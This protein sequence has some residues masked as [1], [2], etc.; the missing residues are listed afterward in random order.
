M[1]PERWQQIRDVLEKALELGPD[2]RSGYLDRA[3][4]SDSSLRHEVEILL[5]SSADVRSSFLQSLT[6]QVTLTPGTKL[7]DYE[8]KS[9]LSSGG[10]GEVYRARDSRLARDVAIK[11]L[12]SFLLADSGRLRRFEQEARAA[13][14][15]SH[16]NILAV[17]QFG[18]YEGVP[19]LVTELLEG[20]TLREQIKRGPVAVRKAIDYGIQMARGL[21]AA[22]EKSIVHRDLKPENLFV[23][24][25][26]R[27]KI[28]D[29]GLAKLT[30]PPSSS[31]HSALT[32]VEGTEA[33]VVMGTVGYMSPEQ[34]RA[35]VADYRSDIFAL[36]A[37][38][39]EM[40]AGKR[41]FQ[42]PTSPETMTAILNEDPPGISQFVPSLPPSLQRVVRRCLEKK[43][44]QRFQSASDL[45]FA[46]DA[47]S[48]VSGSGEAYPRQDTVW[49][50]LFSVVR[51]H[52]LGLAAGIVVVGLVA[53]ALVST[54]RSR[55]SNVPHAK[56]THRQF[57]FS[58]DAYAPAIS[59]DGLF[60]AYVSKKPGEPE[61]LIV[62]ASDGTQLELARRA[63]ISRPRWSP[64]GSELLFFSYD[65]ELEKTDQ[66]AKSGGISVVSRLGG[67]ARPIIRRGYACWLAPDGSQIVAASETPPGGGVRLVNKLTG[68]MKEVRLSEY[69]VL[70]DID[71]SART[72]LILVVTQ[73]SAK[74]QIRTIRPDGSEEHKLVEASDQIYSARWSPS[75]DSIYYLH[76]KGSTKE[77]A[78]VSVTRR[79]AEPEAL[80][81]GLQTGQ[82]FTL[83]ADGSRLGYTREDQTS[84]LWRVDLPA[85]GKKTRPE[86]SRLTSG[87]SHYGAPSF[88]PDGHWIALAFGPNHDETNI[89]K[90]QVAG[91]APVQLTFFEHVTTASPVWSPDGQRIAFISDQGGTPKVWMISA[92]G[93]TAQA[94]ENTNL[95][96]TNNKLAWWPSRDI[97][98]QQLGVQNFLL[99]NDKTHQETPLIPRDQMN[100]WIPFKPV[101]SPDGK[102]MAVWRNRRAESGLYVISLE[103]YSETLLHSGVVQPLGWSPDGKYVYAFGGGEP[104]RE[105]I[106][107]Q[108]ANPSEVT[109]VA[110]LPG[111]V[112][113]YDG[114]SVSPDGKQILAS[115]S[116][117]K[118][119]VW[120]MEN[121]DPS[122]HVKEPQSK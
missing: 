107:V 74:F 43:P 11:V 32:L 33:G 5:A 47:L 15:L 52:K 117:E 92:N 108:V 61:K 50:G 121:F 112:V 48:G 56:I 36:G 1:T 12:P 72:G 58:G 59:P 7:G 106:R 88:S 113:D 73:L 111:D 63:G 66:T 49:S 109:S 82:W 10:M 41:A 65:P 78:R 20:E 55:S 45:A 94:M 26:G 95:S 37:I 9:L 42:K 80:A 35:E 62:Q 67:V 71:C 99:V 98:S 40:L 116:E 51:R 38:L 14:S 93:G 18:R 102:K 64:D 89:F 69:S 16:P 13:A 122:I 104:A 101:F 23:T 70:Y 103:P 114:A 34:V 79:D 68:E 25:D 21:A 39:Y 4:A 60:V 83:S 119:D 120:L 44:E 46:L 22:Q 17:F 28:L 27:V 118:S 100:G 90:M 87:T 75:G 54:R 105:I 85:A 96:D 24:T 30:Q 86:I 3:C 19:Y 53:G 8:V 6:L 97:V 110:T 77:L 84:N 31:E 2:E 115:V 91:G 81:D 76:G 29:F 57:T